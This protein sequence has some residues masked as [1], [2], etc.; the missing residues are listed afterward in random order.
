M[1]GEE[2]CFTDI[3]FYLHDRWGNNFWSAKNTH[4]WAVGQARN[5]VWYWCEHHLG[6][7]WIVQV[8]L[9]LHHVRSLDQFFSVPVFWYSFRY[10]FTTPIVATAHLLMAV[11]GWAWREWWCCS[12]PSTTS[13]RLRCSPATRRGSSRNFHLPVNTRLWTCYEAS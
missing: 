1:I 5:G 10:M 2:I 12:A 9:C 7:H 4:P 13:G 3:Q 6:V 8:C 11:S